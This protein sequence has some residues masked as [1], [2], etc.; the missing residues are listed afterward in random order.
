MIKHTFFFF[1]IVFAILFTP[2]FY[3]AAH[4]STQAEQDLQE[5]IDQLRAEIA[6]L[7]SGVEE[8]GNVVAQGIMDD[9]YNERFGMPVH[10]KDDA[11]LE[12]MG[13]EKSGDS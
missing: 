3:V 13:F 9:R 2:V 12:A 4:D 11:A 5:T 6:S 7:G 8:D 1:I 10:I